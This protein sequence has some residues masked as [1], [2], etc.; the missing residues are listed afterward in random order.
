MLGNRPA[1]KQTMCKT[2]VSSMY[3]TVSRLWRV[4]LWFS[5]CAQSELNQ[6][7]QLVWLERMTDLYHDIH[8]LQKVAN[9]YTMLLF[10]ILRAWECSPSSAHN[11]AGRLLSSLNKREWG[12]YLQNLKRSNNP[13]CFVCPNCLFLEEWMISL[14][15][16]N[17]KLQ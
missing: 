5:G 8:V 17:S 12:C 7:F 3:C 14:L 4:Q 1:W 13:H 10:N 6:S 16:L 15:V 11:L 9:Y 2:H